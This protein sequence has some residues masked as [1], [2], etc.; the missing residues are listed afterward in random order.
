[1]LKLTVTAGEEDQ[2]AANVTCCG[3]PLC[4]GE[5]GL[6]CAECGTAYAPEEVRA[7]TDQGLTALFKFAEGVTV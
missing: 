7:L 1:M 4:D 2:A 5:N 6:F 3:L